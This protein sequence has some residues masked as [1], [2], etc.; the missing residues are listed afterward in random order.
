MNIRE[1][2]NDDLPVLLE[3]E[4]GIIKSERPYD[5]YIKKQG[6]IYYD[7]AGLISGSD[8][9]VVVLEV[10]GQVVGCGYAQLR[11]SKPY[12][13]HGKHC[14][15]E[16]IYLLPEYRGKSLGHEILNFLKSWGIEKG[17]RRFQLGVY[18]DNR[19]AIRAYEKVGFKAVSV[20][21]ELVV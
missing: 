14:Y 19:G 21:M 2:T 1:A 15:L 10:D 17:M 13:T 5:P 18:A 6:V 16:F 9:V 20:M 8:S 4:Q 12:L 11:D 7:L 3:L